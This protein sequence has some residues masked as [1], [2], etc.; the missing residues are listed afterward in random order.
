LGF[1]CK[2]LMTEKE[3]LKEKN[4]LKKRIIINDNLQLL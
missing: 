4:E 2:L 1:V 3:F